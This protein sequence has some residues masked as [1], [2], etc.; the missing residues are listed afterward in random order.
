MNIWKKLTGI[1]NKLRGFDF[2]QKEINKLNN[3]NENKNSMAKKT[4]IT[5]V[6]DVEVNE[7]MIE[8][9]QN[10][11]LMTEKLT[12]DDPTRPEIVKGLQTVDEVFENYKPNVNIEF[13]NSEGVPVKENLAFGNLG[14]F[15]VKGI[16][17]QSDFLKGLDLEKDQ[18][19]K[20]I[21][22]LK[23][24]KPLKNAIADVETKQAMLNAIH[25][26]L[27]ELENAK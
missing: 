18:Y 23:S 4:V 12:Y 17:A 14:D 5:K 16:T 26:L 22:Q 19:Q 25:A 11:T 8:F 2:G 20:I 15:G 1:L 24:N 10:R 27:T 21:K 3:N 7:S 13:Q 6:L 9:P